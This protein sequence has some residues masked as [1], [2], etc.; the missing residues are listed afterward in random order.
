LTDALPAPPVPPSTDLRDFDWMPLD[1]K[2]LRDSETASKTDAEAFRAAV[3]LWCAAWHQVPAAS[4]PDD[5]HELAK[6]A[7]FGRTIKEWRKVRDQALRGFV[8]HSDGRLYHLVVAQKAITSWISKL[9]QRHVSECAKLKKWNQRHPDDP[10]AVPNFAL[11]ITG[12]YPDSAHLASPRTTPN[13]HGDNGESPQGQGSMSPVTSTPRE[14][15]GSNSTQAVTKVETPQQ[16]PGQRPQGQHHRGSARW[17]HDPDAA[18]AKMR[19]LGLTPG[20]GEQMPEC[21]RRI[22]NAIAER[23]RADRQ[24]AA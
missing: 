17:R 20:R 6:F 3:L 4:L 24:S 19:E 15:K 14:V 21:V 23:D 5:E 22:E 7:G 10:V 11:W 12:A 8:K 2:R 18:A 16:P 1:V 13:V 9:Q